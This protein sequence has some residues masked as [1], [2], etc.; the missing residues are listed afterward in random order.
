MYIAHNTYLGILA[1]LHILNSIQNFIPDSTSPSR[2]P[3]DKFTEYE[4]TD[5]QYI[6]LKENKLKNASKF[7]NNGKLA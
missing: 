6:Q 4:E 3:Q 2:G 1:C 7:N 5:R